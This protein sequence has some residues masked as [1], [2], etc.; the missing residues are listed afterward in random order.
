MT[1]VRNLSS[2]TLV[3]RTAPVVES[4]GAGW[5]A[6]TFTTP[7]RAPTAADLRI[8]VGR[9]R[10]WMV[11]LPVDAALLLAPTLSHPR[12]IKASLAFAV[13]SLFFIT[14][15]ERFRARLHLS[16]LDEIPTLVS[17]LL[18]AAALIATYLAFTHPSA[19]RTVGF[20]TDAALAI[21][22]VVAGRVLTTALVAWSRRARLTAHRTVLVGGGA[23]ATEL[24]HKLADSPRY[25]LDVVGFVD[26]S[27]DALATAMVPR[28]GGLA[29]LDR[30]VRIHGADVLIVTDGQFS[31]LAVHDAVRGPHAVH[32]D[33]LVVPRLHHF[34]TATG[35]TDHI[36][37]IP[38][39]RI[40]TPNLVGPGRRVKR[41]FDIAVSAFALLL[42]APLMGLIALAVRR[43]G[44]DVIFRQPRVGE[45]GKIFDVLKFR[46]MRPVDENESATN[47]SIADDDRVGSVGRVLRMTSLDEIPQ[48]WNILRGDM[49]LVGP[50]PERPHFV[51]QFSAQY[52]RYA[53]RHRVKAGLTG[54]SQVSGLRGDTSIADRARYDNYYIENWSLWL[55]VKIILRTV[56][57]VAFAKGR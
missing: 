10:A 57:E 54:M 56:S 9:V 48:L 36:G 25:G 3:R 23:V 15:G 5:P 52:D 50:R 47:W 2:G 16:V 43:E 51:E 42:I 49:S 19:P 55:D 24:A 12:Q 28:L 31:E 39:M 45:N 17:R 30:V 33:L 41:A 26:E 14:G 40:K 13:L 11:L 44:P 21:T 18:M 53:H 1:Y 32:C 22:L 27:D 34:N 4:S 38:V 35:R 8:L 20:L 6:A 37:S 29:D 46:S 7:F